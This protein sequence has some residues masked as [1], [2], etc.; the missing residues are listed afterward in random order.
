MGITITGGIYV[1]P[2]VT[3]ST[4]VLSTPADNPVLITTGAEGAM[5]TISASGVGIYG[6][7]SQAW[8]ITSYGTVLATNIGI[9]LLN[10]GDITNKPGAL[11]SGDGFGINIDNALGHVTNGGSIAGNS[12][13]AIYLNVGGSVTNTGTITSTTRDAIQA[14]SGNTTVINDGVI[15]GYYAG[16]RLQGAG[17]VTNGSTADSAAIITATDS[18]SGPGA[19]GVLLDNGGTINNW[20]TIHAPSLIGRGISLATGGTVLNNGTAAVIEGGAT[21]LLASSGAATIVNQGTI[22]GT[23]A[24]STGIA[25]YGGGTIA[26]AGTIFGGSRAIYASGSP[27]DI[28]NGG[29]ANTT[30]LITNDDA[31]ATGFFYGITLLLDQPGTITNHATIASLG[32]RDPVIYL[33]NGGTVLNL[34]TASH[35]TGAYGIWAESGAIQARNEGTIAG[36]VAVQIDHGG[37]VINT[38]LMTGTFRGISTRYVRAKITNTGTITGGQEAVALGHGGALTNGDAAHRHAAITGSTGIYAGTRAS[39]TNAGTITGTAGNGINLVTAGTILNGFTTG[40]KHVRSALISGQY[41]GISIAGAHPSVV[42]NLGTIAGSTGSGVN[43]QAGTVINSGL[44]TGVTGITG[45]NHPLT[46]FNAGTNTGTGGTAIAFGNQDGNLLVLNRGAVFNGV[47]AG[48]TLA[49]TLQLDGGAIFTVTGKLAAKFVAFG[50]PLTNETLRSE[51]P[52]LLKSIITGFANGD[53]IDLGNF[54]A[55]T[56]AATFANHTLTLPELGGPGTVTLHF[57]P[58]I[59]LANLT[60]A[61][62]GSGGT[63]V[64]H[65]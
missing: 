58:G 62:D 23:E 61:P 2:T 39:I 44:I 36:Y 55:D 18:A 46:I 25:L 63:N 12:E 31:S 33:R 1:T 9:E 28:T 53:T 43:I 49:D 22:G 42:A 11:I 14:E 60:F 34:G 24:A 20:G 51:T 56:P 8:T 4:V 15:T 3:T 30:A 57:S 32:A 52:S 10:G 27:I 50:S 26:N 5:G 29:P 65:I 64:L 35:I 47:V 45:Y 40:P 21:G 54:T 41:D 16:I 38:G 6:H 37:R 59:S 48:G 17:M 13:V 19:A 7:G